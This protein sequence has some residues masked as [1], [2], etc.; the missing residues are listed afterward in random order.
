MLYLK[1]SKVESLTLNLLSPLTLLAIGITLIALEAITFS[2]VLFWFGISFLLVA[3]FSLFDIYTNGLWQLSSVALIAIV[4][5]LLLRTKIMKLFLKS[6]EEH[7][8]NFLNEAGEG[9]IKDSKVYYK[10]TYWSIGYEGEETF[11]EGE[12]VNVLST[13]RGIANIEKKKST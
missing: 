13:A 8:D 6:K 1:D 7:N 10:A 12:K 2:F 3:I 11:N 4:L 9:F 5:L